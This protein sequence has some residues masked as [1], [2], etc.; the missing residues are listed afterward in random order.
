S[1]TIMR[2]DYFSCESKHDST[3]CGS[4]IPQAGFFHNG[5]NYK[6]STFYTFSLTQAANLNIKTTVTNPQCGNRLMRLYASGITNQCVD[7]DVADMI[8]QSLDSIVL[9][10]VPP[11]DYTLQISGSDQSNIPISNSGITN[12]NTP[13][14]WKG[15]LGREFQL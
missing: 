3:Y 2:T 8:Q 4:A 11:G 6:Y 10:C 5:Q 9:T 13:L 12:S 14:C 7:L 1:G 15:L